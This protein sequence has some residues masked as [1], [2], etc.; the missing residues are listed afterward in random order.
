M[1]L[2]DNQRMVAQTAML[3]VHR[4]DLETYGRMVASGA[5]DQEPVE[6]LD[7][8][9]VDVSPQGPKHGYLIR[10][11]TRHLAGAHAW[12]DVQLPLEVPPD[13][14]PEP[15][16]ALVEEN[17]PDRHP[18]TAL[19]VVE[20]AVTSHAIDRDVKPSQY[21]RAGVPTYW[22]VDVPARAVF[23][24][25]DPEGDAYRTCTEYRTGDRVPSPAA[26]VPELDV[27]ELFGSTDG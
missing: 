21:A 11:L 23:V 10:R 22:L 20:V 13:S 12:L 6:L 1:L 25:T 27:G 9:L 2:C 19:L 5:L 17:V 18:R 24:Y 26:G 4:L 15:D 3:P 8:L 7:G 14:L 16:L